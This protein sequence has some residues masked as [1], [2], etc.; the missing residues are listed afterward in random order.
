MALQKPVETCPSSEAVWH[1][2]NIHRVNEGLFQDLRLF[3]KAAE[4]RGLSFWI[5]RS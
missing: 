1:P 3:Q 4:E 5:L 2:M